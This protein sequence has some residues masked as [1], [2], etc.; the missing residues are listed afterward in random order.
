[1]AKTSERHTEAMIRA[2]D[3]GG[4]KTLVDVGGGFGGTLAAILAAFPALQGV[5]FDLPAD[6][7][8]RRRRP[9]GGWARGALPGRGRGHA[10]RRAARRRRLPASTSGS[11]ARSAAPTR[12]PWPIANMAS[13]ATARPSSTHS[14]ASASTV[15]GA[16]RPRRSIST[17][18]CLERGPGG[19]PGLE[20][21]SAAGMTADAAHL[22]RR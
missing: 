16:R 8:R 5:V 1:M 12:D 4:I 9:R 2:Y 22:G 11:T 10:A 15:T 6:R 13:A 18:S 7:G 20:R 21:E 3:F 19:K 17:R 14:R